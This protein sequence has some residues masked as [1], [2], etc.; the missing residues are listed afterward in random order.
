[1]TD[2]ELRDA[3]ERAYNLGAGAARRGVDDPASRA[4]RIYELMEELYCPHG[5]HT[6]DECKPVDL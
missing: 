5:R 6:C 4:A 3:L 2:E 1:M